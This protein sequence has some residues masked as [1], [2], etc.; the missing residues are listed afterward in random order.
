MKESWAK[1]PNTIDSD[2]LE[3]VP[4]I[5]EDTDGNQI[6][7]MASDPLNAIVLVTEL[8]LEKTK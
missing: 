2:K 8:L 6:E 7:I 4:H 1:Y 5:V 3:K